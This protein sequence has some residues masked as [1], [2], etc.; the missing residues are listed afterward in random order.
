MSIMFTPTEN[1]IRGYAWY[2]DTG[3]FFLYR[4]LGELYLT[5]RQEKKLIVFPYLFSFYAWC[6]ESGQGIPKFR[7]EI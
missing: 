3:R 5:D 4:R 1:A 6:E 2:D 7:Q